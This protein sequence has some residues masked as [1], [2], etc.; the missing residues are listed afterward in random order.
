[1]AGYFGGVA[2]WLIMRIAEFVILI[3][4]LY[5]ILFPALGPLP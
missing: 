5:L 2:D 4:G 1:L 3:P